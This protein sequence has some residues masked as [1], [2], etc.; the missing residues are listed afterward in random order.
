[1]RLSLPLPEGQQF[2]NIGRPIIALSPD[3]TNVVYVA[4][5]RLYLRPMSG[6]ESRVIPGSEEPGAVLNP[7]F[8][9]DGQAVAFASVGDAAIKRLPISGGAAVTIC[10]N[11]SVV[12]LELERG[13]HPVRPAK[14]HPA[15]GPGRRHA[16]ESSSLP[17]PARW[18]TAPQM[19]PG[20]KAVLFSIKKTADAW[21]QG[22]IVVQPL[23]GGPRKTVIDGGAAGMYVPTGHLVYAV[24]TVLF[25]VPFNLDS[26]AV[27]GGPVSIVEGVL[28]GRI[29]ADGP[30][31]PATAHYSYSTTGSL[32]FIPGTSATASTNARDLALFDRTA[33]P[34]PLGLPPAAYASPRVSP[35]G[36]WAAFEREDGNNADIWLFELTGT[37]AI[38]RLT[39]G[40]RE[41]SAGL[42]RGF[43]MD[44]L[45]V[46]PGRRRR[47]LPAT[48]RWLRYSRAADQTGGRGGPRSSSLVSRRCSCAVHSHE[49]WSVP[50][51][52]IWQ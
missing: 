3:G 28:R 20:G 46:Q 30:T 40:R 23:G 51:C 7:V 45:P 1:M 6:Y 32:A 43:P 47:D 50:R 16:R 15:C 13:R 37:S 41:P 25:A 33:P 26:Y 42:V 24:S 34:Q 52:G 38:R 18:W 19:L 4:N 31:A 22:Q 14:G 44:R 21:D 27:S 29:K 39:F 8:S 35:D 49:G 36:K 11:R 9:P 10:Q 48:R 2:S 17:L 12:R 5:R